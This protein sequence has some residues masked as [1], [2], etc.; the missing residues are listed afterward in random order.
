MFR[1]SSFNFRFFSF[2]AKG[3]CS[4][5]SGSGPGPSA[6][7]IF[8]PDRVLPGRRQ[9]QVSSLTRPPPSTAPAT[10]PTSC[11]MTDSFIQFDIIQI[12]YC[13]SKLAS[14]LA[15]F[16]PLLVFFSID[17]RKY[18]FVKVNFVAGLCLPEN[19]TKIDLNPCS[20]KQDR[21]FKDKLLI[22]RICL[23]G[24]SFCELLPS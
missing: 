16:K 17:V 1:P 12:I 5:G 2:Q 3:Q 21:Q 13:L 8:Q 11:L 7:Q 23:A 4:D 15:V 14:F 24:S 22:C 18:I 19:T 20:V 10:L 6:L 9:L